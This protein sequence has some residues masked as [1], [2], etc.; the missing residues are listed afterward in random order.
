[1]RRQMPIAGAELLATAALEAIA[2]D[3][4]APDG[5]SQ[6]VKRN[7]TPISK[8]FNQVL[9]IQVY[10]PAYPTER[11]SAPTHKP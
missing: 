4:P 7:P 6:P 9:M 3:P 5:A 11:V 2:E 8:T 10:N 1:M